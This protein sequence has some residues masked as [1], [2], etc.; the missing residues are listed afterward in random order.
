MDS[1]T[2]PSK[3]WRVKCACWERHWDTATGWREGEA[4]ASTQTRHGGSDTWQSTIRQRRYDEQPVQAYKH[5][6]GQ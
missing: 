1:E 2:C 5:F 3:L 4:G 6:S